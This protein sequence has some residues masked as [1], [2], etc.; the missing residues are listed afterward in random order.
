MKKLLLSVLLAALLLS[1]AACGGPTEPTNASPPDT[2][3]PT[4]EPA[5]PEEPAQG[6]VRILNTDPELNQIWDI[7]AEEY[8][9]FTGTDVQ[10]VAEEADLPTLRR[11]LFR[12][13]LPESC[14]DLSQTNACAQLI[15]QELTL[16]DEE[17][18]VLA[19]ADSIEV[20][21]LMYNSTLLAQTANTRDDINSF[22]DLTEV[23]YSITD[24]KDSLGFSAFARVDPDDHFA[25]QIATLTGDS[26]NL[27]ELIMNNTTGDPL[28]VEGGTKSEALQDFLE[29]KAVF[30]LAGSAEQAVLDAIGS[31]NIGVLPVYIGGENEEKQTLCVAPRSFWCVDAGTSEADVQA[32]VDFLEFLT[33]PRADGTVPADALGRVTPYRQAAYVS[34]VPEVVLRADLAMGKEP[35]VCRYMVQ[36]PPGLTDA[37]VAY[38]ADPSDNNWAAIR[39]ILEAIE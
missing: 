28:A 16:R 38:V 13:E 39:D 27:V 37:L 15:S 17:G 2:T 30:F 9:R 8:T 25:L 4:E 20:Y 32:T 21:G 7:L 29:G 5:P 26:R 36:V 23:V 18:A 33:M 3:A 31:E 35:V 34:N 11:V 10:I 22:A 6:Q 24:A 19:V 12:D 14:A 1:L